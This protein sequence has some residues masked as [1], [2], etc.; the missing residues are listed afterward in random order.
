[1]RSSNVRWNLIG[2]DSVVVHFV[3]TEGLERFFAALRRLRAGP[4]GSLATTSHRH[5]HQPKQHSGACNAASQLRP[6]DLVSDSLNDLHS[7]ASV[8]SDNGQL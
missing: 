2:T 7:G 8:I 1:M 6:F 4:L 5:Q 3:F